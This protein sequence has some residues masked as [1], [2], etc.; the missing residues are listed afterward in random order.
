[1]IGRVP[2]VG[3]GGSGL[4]PRASPS[5]KPEPPEPTRGTR[6]LI[7]Q[8]NVS[9][10]GVPKLPVPEARLTDMGLEGDAVIRAAA[11]ALGQTQSST[12]YDSLIKLIDAP[13]W[14]ERSQPAARQAASPTRA[15]PRAAR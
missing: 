7:H 3:S 1:M 5:N 10:G 8:L 6:G 4:L 13:S 2:R 9:K 15:T 11:L 14:R 12:A